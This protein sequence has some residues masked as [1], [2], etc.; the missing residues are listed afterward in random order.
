M[1]DWQLI[2]TAPKDG[3]PILIWQPTRQR[4]HYMPDGALKDGECSYTTDDPRLKFFD[5]ERYAI[6]YWRPWG[7]WGDRNH[8]AV[9]PTH[10]TPLPEPPTARSAEPTRSK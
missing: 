5:D 7:S 9:E 8:S 1:S 2:E 6:G 3:T 10:W 4:S